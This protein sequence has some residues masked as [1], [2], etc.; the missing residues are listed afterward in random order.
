MASEIKGLPGLNYLSE[1][2]RQAF[3]LSNEDKL[4][5]YRKPGDRKRAADILYNN[6]LF[7]DTFGDDVFRQLNDG[8]EASYNLRNNM[9]TEKAA[10]IRQHAREREATEGLGDFINDVVHCQKCGKPMMLI[11]NKKGIFYLKCSGC[12][13]T[14]YLTEE[15][16]NFYI[17]QKHVTCPIHHCRIY[18]RLGRYGIYVRCTQGGHYLK[19]D[20]I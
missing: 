1:R 10:T 19:P 6:T 8:T 15:I 3:M 9:L 5:K 18:A 12:K 11:K 2:E 7:K 20:E 16:V 14:A 13:G 17:F 4:K